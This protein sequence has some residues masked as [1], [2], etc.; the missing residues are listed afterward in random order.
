LMKNWISFGWSTQVAAAPI[1]TATRRRSK[2]RLTQ[3]D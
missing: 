1:A 3:P 2:L